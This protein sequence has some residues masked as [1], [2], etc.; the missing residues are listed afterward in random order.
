MLPSQGRKAVTATTTSRQKVANYDD[1]VCIYTT[2]LQ[3][4]EHTTLAAGA[5]AHQLG[6]NFG[7]PHD[8]VLPLCSCN[9]SICVMNSAFL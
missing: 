3:D 9:V 4:D 8:D 2:F 5:M 7:M 1:C 6:R